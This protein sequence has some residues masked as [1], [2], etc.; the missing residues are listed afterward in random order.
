M[1]F[2]QDSRT[3]KT[4]LLYLLLFTFLFLGCEQSQQDQRTQGVAVDTTAVLSAIDSLRNS[5]Q[6]AVATENYKNLSSLVTES[7]IMVQPGSPEWESMRSETQYPFPPGATIDIK[8]IEVQVMSEKWA[9]EY[10]NATIT[11]T[12]KGSKELKTLRD[13]YLVLLKNTADGWKV[14][15]EVA[16][17]YL[18]ENP[19]KK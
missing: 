18:P 10:G 8:P 14:H 13:S 5:Y 4:V 11:Y 19:G 6:E 3:S 16:S 15:R 17:S 1:F 9:Y 7:A 2:N 12:P